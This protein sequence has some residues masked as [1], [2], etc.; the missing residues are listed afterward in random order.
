MASSSF[1]PGQRAEVR[2][3][4]IVS[5]TETVVFSSTTLFVEAPNWHPDGGSL[6]LNAE[7]GLVRL[8]LPGAGVDE[9]AVVE[10]VGVPDLVLNN[11]HVIS[12]D[13][14]SM[15]VTA[16]DGHLYRLPWGGG[17]AVRLTPGSDPARRFKYYLHAV[18]PDGSTIAAVGGGVDD[19]GEWVTNIVTLPATG[20]AE[21]GAHACLTDD[22]FADDGPDFSADGEWIWFNSERAGE[23]PGHAQ[24]FRMRRDGAELTRVTHDDRVNWFPHPSPDGH[25]VLYLSYPRGTTGHPPNLDVELR[26]IELASGE[27][28]TVASFYGGQGSTNVPGWSPDGRRVA[29]VAYPVGAV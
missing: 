21:G 10:T 3:F 1:L 12:P 22:A 4:D 16:R 7:G 8:A 14:T 13:G 26:L 15:L 19:T 17:D 24:L 29:Y 6:L 18:S 27:A 9:A 20:I 2:L 28:R 23:Y 25:H 5:G 11:D